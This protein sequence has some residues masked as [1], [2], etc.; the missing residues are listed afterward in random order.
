[1]R[2]PAA[3]ERAMFASHAQSAG[4]VL[5]L[6]DD[7]D[8]AASVAALI[9]RAGHLVAIVSR[10]DEAL[11]LVRTGVVKLLV[12]DWDLRSAPEGTEL[13]LQ[14]KQLRRRLPLLVI[15]ADG[16]SLSVAQ[17]SGARHCL[18]KPFEGEA[19]LTLIQQLITRPGAG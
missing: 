12:M 17:Q 6:D 9:E 15:S 13:I 2:H 3:Q 18:Q 1:M 10:G 16:F 7:P 8:I 11:V 4:I 19:L 14:V 5:V